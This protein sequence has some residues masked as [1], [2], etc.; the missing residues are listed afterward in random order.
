MTYIE[1][2]YEKL[3]EQSVKNA[4]KYKKHYLCSNTQ[5]NLL[6][7]IRSLHYRMETYLKQN[8]LSSYDYSKQVIYYH[9]TLHGMVE[10]SYK[11]YYIPGG[12]DFLINTRYYSNYIL[13]EN[14][15]ENFLCQ[16][17]NS[18]YQKISEYSEKK[19]KGFRDA[20]IYDQ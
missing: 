15:N 13:L 10:N 6:D 7:D 8:D 1:S 12:E 20:W 19:F 16:D 17:K 4:Q 14:E 5:N 3:A 18:L 9:N 11:F 2:P